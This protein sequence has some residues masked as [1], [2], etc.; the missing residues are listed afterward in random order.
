[1]LDRPKRLSAP[2][3]P[4]SPTH[5]HCGKLNMNS[6]S[7]ET[8]EF[9]TSSAEAHTAIQPLHMDCCEFSLDGAGNAILCVPTYGYLSDGSFI[10]IPPSQSYNIAAQAWLAVSQTDIDGC[11]AQQTDSSHP[12][13]SQILTDVVRASII[14]SFAQ[15]LCSAQCTDVE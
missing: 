14:A 8:S 2:Q 13:L 12:T 9:L 3:I 6:C 10:P 11:L 7:H 1:M 5:S 4:P 15:L